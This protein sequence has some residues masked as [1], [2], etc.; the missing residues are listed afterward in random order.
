MKKTA[1]IN[2]MVEPQTKQ[3][4][5]DKAKALSLTLTSYFE[6]IAN[7]PVCFLDSNVKMI[8]ESLKLKS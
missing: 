4:L 3:R 5:Q 1:Q 7:E 8:L 2:I 6:K